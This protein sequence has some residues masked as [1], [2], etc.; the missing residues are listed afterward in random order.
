ML[1]L[2]NAQQLTN[3]TRLTGRHTAG[4]EDSSEASIATA[5]EDDFL[6]NCRLVGSGAEAPGPPHRLVTLEMASRA[7]R[8]QTGSPA[9]HGARLAEASAPR[10][11]EDPDPAP[12]A[13][14]SHLCHTPSS[15][16]PPAPRLGQVFT[17]ASPHLGHL[18]PGPTC[19]VS[20]E[21]LIPWR[22]K[23]RPPPTAPLSLACWFPSP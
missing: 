14:T 13:A 3:H 18:L 17:L 4:K 10:P 1:Q 7:A 8:L 15:P 22:V 20:A 21:I 12:K 9:P 19:G 23:D 11:N 6:S 2:L 5:Y 16:R